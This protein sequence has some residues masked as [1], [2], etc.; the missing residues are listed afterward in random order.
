MMQEHPQAQ[1]APCQ[2]QQSQII[3]SGSRVLLQQ[4]LVAQPV[5]HSSQSQARSRRV[6]LAASGS[7]K[8]SRQFLQ[9]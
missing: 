4:S 8:I 9:P 3:S 1:P 7:C 6:L 2:K 5:L